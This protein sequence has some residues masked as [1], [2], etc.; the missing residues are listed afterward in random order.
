MADAEK[1]E[2]LPGEHKTEVALV[3]N[4]ISSLEGMQSITNRL[5]RDVVSQL[6]K[7]V[8]AN[9]IT[10]LLGNLLPM[11]VEQKQKLLETLDVN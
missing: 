7:G 1:V 10:D 5:P 9:D 3:R 2:D 8:S 4:I 6:S 11:P